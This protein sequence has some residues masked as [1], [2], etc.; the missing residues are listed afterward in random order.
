MR[1]RKCERCK[2]R[3]EI[4]SQVFKQTK[5]EYKPTKEGYQKIVYYTKK[6]WLCVDCLIEAKI[7]EEE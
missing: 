2:K 7:K 4:G 3:N 5:K 1:K 6:V